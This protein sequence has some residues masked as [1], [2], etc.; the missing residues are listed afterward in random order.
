MKSSL[1]IL[2]AFAAFL[3]A[4]LSEAQECIRGLNAAEAEKL[5]KD[6]KSFTKD[7]PCKTNDVACIGDAFAKCASTNN[8]SIQECAAGLKCSV[9]PLV[10]KR[11]TSI[12]CDT[13]A[14]RL[15]RIKDAKDSCKNNPKR[16]RYPPSFY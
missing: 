2:F 6:F 10:L 8:W 15:A 16:R 4:S 13:E 9:L 7:T 5:Q 3:L 1:F 12:A 14:D 11:G